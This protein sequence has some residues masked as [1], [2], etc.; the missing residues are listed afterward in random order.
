M[1]LKIILFSTILFLQFVICILASAQTLTP[2]PPTCTGDSQPCKIDGVISD[3]DGNL[4]PIINIGTQVWMA[5]NLKVTKYHNGTAITKVTNEDIWSN[6]KTEAYCIHDSIYGA[7]YNWY[8]VNTGKLCPIGWHV[9]TD[10]EWTTM[11]NHLGGDSVA[12]GK[13]KEC[14]TTHWATPNTEA[15]NETCFSALPGGYRS[16][17]GYVNCVGSYTHWWTSTEKDANKAW[18]RDVGLGYASVYR[19]DLFKQDGFSIRCL[20]D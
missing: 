20:K 11:T 15:T 18:Y 8:S 10:A 17:N 13:L 9:P 16:L 3:I 5:Q 19:N 1:K 14:G 2:L 7:L 4:Y 12:G 6:Q